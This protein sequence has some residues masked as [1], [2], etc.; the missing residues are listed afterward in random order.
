MRANKLPL[1]PFEIV[2]NKIPLYSVD[3]GYLIDSKTGYIKINR[4]AATTY[5]EFKKK[6]RPMV[7]ENKIE[8]LVIDLRQNP[9]GYLQA[10]AQIADELLSGEKIIVYTKGKAY[11]RQ[12]Y[13][14]GKPG[15]F[16]RGKLVILIDQGSASA[17][18]ILAGA[19]QDWDRGTI[20]GRTS[21]GKGLVQEQYDLSDGSGLRL[22]VARYYTPS[23]RCIQKSY[24]K[25]TAAY[26]D[27]IASRFKNGELF[28]DDSILQKD[29][30]VFETANGRKV[31]GGG[32]IHPD[33]FVPLDTSGNLDYYFGFAN[34]IP[35]FVYKNYSRFSTKIDGYKNVA[36]YNQGFVVED[37][38]FNDFL[39]YAFS[40]K[41]KQ[42][43]AKLAVIKPKLLIQLKA[44]FARQRWQQEGYLFV[45][46][47][48][49]KDLQK[50]LESAQ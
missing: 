19:I 12:D 42:D 1:K 11:D 27:E 25:G 32:G 37:A 26:Y 46:K 24:D 16:E 44:Y 38:L 50:A 36:E 17:S 13:M 49:D 18:E 22:T 5:E 23:G 2:R 39:Q 40:Q 48:I 9:G 29:S 7:E 3:A 47:A 43:D 28:K 4:F 20:V 31:F 30:L 15:L 35:E 45:T 41:I 10:A 8:K 6:L 14:S 33:V 21:F 34:F